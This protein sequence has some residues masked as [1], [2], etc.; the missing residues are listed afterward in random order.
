MKRRHSLT[1]VE[2]A[3]AMAVCP[4]SRWNSRRKSCQKSKS[5][6]ALNMTKN[7]VSP[8]AHRQASLSGKRCTTFV[9]ATTVRNR[10]NR[11]SPSGFPKLGVLA[12]TCRLPSEGLSHPKRESKRHATAERESVLP[13]ESHR[14][15]VRGPYQM[16]SSGKDIPGRRGRV[17][18]SKLVVRLAGV[19]AV[20]ATRRP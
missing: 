16:R 18:Q 13:S 8:P 6:S 17:C 12:L 2:P 4:A 15:F 10:L 20:R 1:E 7:R 5:S 9:K 11:Q 14:E 19:A 3:L